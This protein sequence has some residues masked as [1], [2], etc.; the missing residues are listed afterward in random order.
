MVPEQD[1]YMMVVCRYL[2]SFFGGLLQVL[3]RVASFWRFLLRR[4]TTSTNIET[5]WHPNR[6]QMKP[7]W[8]RGVARVWWSWKVME[9]GMPKV[10][11]ISQKMEALAVQAQIF[12]FGGVFEKC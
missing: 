10:I 3:G 7:N 6:P 11:Q 1:M 9:K 8:P 5:E 12:E 2:G 4:S